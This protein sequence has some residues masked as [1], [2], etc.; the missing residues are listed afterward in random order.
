[1]HF[2]A[3]YSYSSIHTCTFRLY[4]STRALKQ[5]TCMTLLH[6]LKQYEVLPSCIPNCT[7]IKYVRS[8]IPSECTIQVL[9]TTL[10]RVLNSWSPSTMQYRELSKGNASLYRS[11]S[12]CCRQHMRSTSK[13]TVL[14]I[15]ST[16]NSDLGHSTTV[17]VPYDTSCTEQYCT[18]RNSMCDYS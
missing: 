14:E 11:R 16:C 4:T 9:T 13:T 18:S 8:I 17:L 15:D 1:M 3:S 10:V 12:Q 2:F 5:D 7:K 6:T